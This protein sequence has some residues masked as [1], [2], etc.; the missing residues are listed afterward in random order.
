VEHGISLLTAIS[1]AFGLALIFGFSADRLTPR[2]SH[3][4]FVIA[5]SVQLR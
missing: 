3:R 2:R 4:F 1:A 5:E